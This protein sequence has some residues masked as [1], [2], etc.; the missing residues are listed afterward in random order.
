[1]GG[2]L[3]NAWKVSAKSGRLWTDNPP[4]P[5][6]TPSLLNELD[7][8]LKLDTHISLSRSLKGSYL[9]TTLLLKYHFSSAPRTLL[10][11]AFGT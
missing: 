6:T 1:M 9:P 11:V 4:D 10:T 7:V 8:G 3:R 5:N 2:A